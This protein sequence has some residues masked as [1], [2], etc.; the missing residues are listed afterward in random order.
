MFRLHPEQQRPRSTAPTRV[1][2]A[3]DLCARRLPRSRRGVS[4]FNSLHFNRPPARPDRMGRERRDRMGRERRDRRFRPCRKGS[5][6]LGSVSPTLVPYQTFKPFN[7]QTCQRSSGS[8]SLS[9][10][11]RIRTL[12]K[13]ARKPFGIRTFKTQDLKGDYVFDTDACYGRETVAGECLVGI[14]R[15]GRPCYHSCEMKVEKRKFDQALK[16]MLRAKP[17]PRKKIKTRGRRG[18]KTPILAKP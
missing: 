18:V 13:P 8:R 10:S 7:L 1:A 3:S 4:A 16:K 17:E 9:N 15:T 6:F 5:A 14:L 11:F 2:S 12:E